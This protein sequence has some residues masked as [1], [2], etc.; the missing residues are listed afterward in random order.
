MLLP[1]LL[2]LFVAL[3]SL[4]QCSPHNLEI[5]AAAAGAYPETMVS[6]PESIGTSLAKRGWWTNLKRGACRIGCAFKLTS[7]NSAGNSCAARRL[8]LAQG[9]PGAQK[10]CNVDYRSCY[11][12]C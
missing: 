8:I 11:D 7:C 1:R 3:I 10:W 5:R 9:D 2:F 6:V 12:R 4:T